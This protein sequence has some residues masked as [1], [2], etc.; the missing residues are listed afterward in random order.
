MAELANDAAIGK[1]N[2]TNQTWYRPVAKVLR[3]ASIVPSAAGVS[4]AHQNILLIARGAHSALGGALHGR[5]CRNRF[6]NWP[7]SSGCGSQPDLHRSDELGLVM[8][9][10]KG[11]QQGIAER[12]RQLV[13]ASTL[14]GARSTAQFWRWNA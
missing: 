14:T 10:F 12:E 13:N 5:W 4:S 2:R 6:S 11:M 3:H 9:V 1:Q 7:R 8:S